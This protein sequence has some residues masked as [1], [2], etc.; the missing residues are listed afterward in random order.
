[1]TMTPASTAPPA[2]NVVFGAL[3]WVG[4]GAWIAE[5][6]R[7][8]FG[9]FGDGPGIVSALVGAVAFGFGI[10]RSSRMGMW[11]LL[12]LALG[13]AALIG[14]RPLIGALPPGSVLLGAVV[15][16]ALTSLGASLVLACQSLSLN[17]LSTTILFSGGAVACS[18]PSGGGALLA[19]GCGALVAAL[20]GLGTRSFPAPPEVSF[21]NVGA[22][23]SIFFI[24]TLGALLTL[25]AL[26]GPLS[27]APAGV[28]AFGCAMVLGLCVRPGWGTAATGAAGAAAVGLLA[29]Q[30]PAR[31]ATL[32]AALG[33]RSAALAEAD[34]PAL[35]VLAT[36]GLALGLLAGLARARRGEKAVGALLA[37]A[38]APLVAPL[39]DTTLSEHASSALATV[40][41]DVALRA[42]LD[43][44]RAELP[45]QYAQLG[46]FGGALIRGRSGQ[47]LAEIDGS[48]VDPGSRSAASDRFAGTLG[49]CLTSARSHARVGGD[50]TGGALSSLLAQGFQTVDTALPDTNWMHTWSDLDP[51]A[52]AAWVHPGTRIL[53]L[54]GSFVAESGDPADVVVQIVRNGWTDAR[55]GLPS[56]A[57]MASS[58]RSLKPGGAY[59]LSVSTT[60]IDPDAF[61]G[62]AH[63]LTGEFPAVTVWLPPVGVDSAML[64]AR[65]STDPLVWSGLQACIDNDRQRLRR[66]AVRIPAD[67]ASLLLGDA[68]TIPAA[69]APTGFRLPER[70]AA[71]DRNPLTLIQ[72][73]H[74]DPAAAWSSDA[75]V[76]DLR[77]RHA[78]LLR[79][80]SVIEQAS[81]GDMHGAIEA[82]RSLSSAPGGG[83]SIESLVRGYLDAARAHIAAASRQG[84]DSKEWG[85][86]ETALGNVRL[87]YPDLAEA[88]C[89]EG[90]MDEARGQLP[91]AE[92]AYS[93]CSGKD[94]DSLEALQGLAR[95]RRA[96]GN[97]TGAEESLRNAVDRHP[98]SWKPHLQLGVL[99]LA[100][101]RLD[102]AEPLLK[103]AVAGSSKDTDPPSEP[104]LALAHLYLATD[105]PALALG[106]AQQVV[107]R[108][109]DPD[110][111]AVRGMARFSLNQL[112]LAENDFREALKMEADS[113]LARGGLAEVQLAKGDFDGAVTSFKAVLQ[114]DPQ[115]AAAR[116]NLD[117]LAAQGKE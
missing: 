38:A 32:T 19:L 34:R 114:T 82:A 66:D 49:G 21:T 54:P 22:R 9:M 90:L 7:T 28:A 10:F 103:E 45:L 97:L 53:T 51:V 41:A 84:P 110:A 116:Q 55:G 37:A 59:V 50:D 95:T 85:A 79:F 44:A 74:W 68:T 29:Q 14:A 35:V 39:L 57:S 20:G 1:M 33:H 100:L 87:L 18:L 115:N 92:E 46:A 60:R 26:R 31:M 93:T 69:R 108:K 105:R 107:S 102:A 56:P 99:Y 83:R 27:P 11:R 65:S 64:V 4:I 111:L 36:S 47:L 8:Y 81:T 43:S 52:Q 91:R 75:P 106:E 13:G 61:V 80:Q 104:H 72:A 67:V 6:C 73:E 71:G 12:P 89:V 3:S 78:S 70:L 88:W 117:R 48:V 63:A 86:A 42:R 2:R 62:L 101:G 24:S 17:A 5:L 23:T 98:E 94:P 16:G 58:R 113:V 96:R 25:A 112:D 40:G 109:A 30:L 77:A 76:D 15:L